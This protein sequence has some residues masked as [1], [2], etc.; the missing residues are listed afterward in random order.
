MDTNLACCELK[1]STAEDPLC[2]RG[3][4]MLNM[5]M[6][7]CLPLVWCGARKLIVPQLT[8]TY[9]QAAQSSTISTTT[10]TEP[11]TTNITCPPL[12]CRKPVS[13][14]NPMPN[15]STVSTPSSSTQA[16]LLLSTSA[17]IPTI[18][19]ESLLSIPIPPPT[20]TSPGNNLNTSASSLETEKHALLQLLINVLHFQ[21]KFNH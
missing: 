10:Q 3:R 2:R 9:A 11:N 17:M 1:T 19:S 5:L 8:Q 15:T 6:L 18:Q 14:A 20:T 4:N 7:K 13:S 16:H 21:L 12:H